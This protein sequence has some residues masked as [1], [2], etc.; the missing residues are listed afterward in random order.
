MTTNQPRFTAI[1]AE[2]LRA[3]AAALADLDAW[4]DQIA[5]LNVALI[6]AAVARDRLAELG[7]RMDVEEARIVLETVGSNADTRK[8][9][10]TLAL[11][12]ACPAYQ[13]LLAQNREARQRLAD[14]ERRAEIAR[15]QCRL[16]RAATLL[17]TVVDD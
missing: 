17:G 9:A 11:H 16:L 12:E 14:A 2:Q 1:D 15:Q 5:A 8:A 3:Q 6:D 13:Q 4:D 7:R 10:V